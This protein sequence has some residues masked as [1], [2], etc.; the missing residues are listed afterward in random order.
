[1]VLGAVTTHSCIKQAPLL[2]TEDTK[3]MRKALAFCRK[4]VHGYSVS[5]SEE[6]VAPA[7]VPAPVHAKVVTRSD[8]EIPWS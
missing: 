4:I 2:A 8:V 7:A 1:M 6:S 5:V 3:A